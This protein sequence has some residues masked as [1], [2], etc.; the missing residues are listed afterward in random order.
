M[1]EEQQGQSLN[2]AS[3]T[4]S[5]GWCAAMTSAHELMPTMEVSVSPID[6]GTSGSSTVTA[7]ADTGASLCIMNSTAW[8][9]IAYKTKLRKS[10]A[11]I[12]VAKQNYELKTLGEAEC[13]ITLN[14][15]SKS[16]TQT[17]VVVETA[18][19]EMFLSRR[20]LTELGVLPAGFP[21]H[22]IKEM[23]ANISLRTCGC[24]TREMVPA[25]T[26]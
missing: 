25:P 15:S 14:N 26:E 18:G 20:V 11:V 22:I 8:S 1:N 17:V 7:L 5:R 13:D 3:A 12:G 10:N 9:R 23:A 4:L 2:M 16:T 6:S 24:P 19:Y 21:N